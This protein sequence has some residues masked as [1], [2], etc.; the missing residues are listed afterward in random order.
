MLE[1]YCVKELGMVRPIEV[2][3]SNKEGYT[4][5][6]HFETTEQKTRYGEN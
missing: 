3:L 2:P 5:R 4:T 6:I 1:H